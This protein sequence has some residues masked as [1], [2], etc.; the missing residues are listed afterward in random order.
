MKNRL[1]ISYCILCVIMTSCKKDL[2]NQTPLTSISDSQVWSDLSLARAYA[3]NIYNVLPGPEHMWDNNTNRTWVLSSSC[4]EGFN[5][6]DDY[7]EFVINS[8]NVT[9]DNLGLFDIWAPTYNYIQDCNIFLSKIDNVPGDAT[10]RNQLKG[11][12]IYL[13]AYAYFKLIRDYGGVPIVTTPSELNT[14][15]N[16]SRSTFD[17][18]V[19]FISSELDK[20]AALLPAQ[21]TSD[22]YGRATSPAA[23]ALKSTVLLYDASPLWNT[24]ND[25]TKWQKASDAANA[26]ISLNAF[27]L[28]NGNY[29]DLFST[30]QNPELIM[31]RQMNQQY[32][33]NAFQGAEMFLSPSGFNGWESFAPS[34]KLVDAFGM[35]NG[36][37]ITDPGSGY[38]PQHPYV[39]RDPRFYQD[40]IFDGRPYGQPAFCQARYA[41]GHSNVTEFFE[42]GLDSPQGWDNWN[43]GLTRYAFRK[44]QDTTYNF[45]TL[46]QTNKYW[47]ISRLSEIYLNYAEAQFNLGNNAIAIQYLNRL[48]QRAGITNPLPATLSGA[49]L[50][51]KIQNERQ[52]ELCLE[53]HRYYDVRRW[54]IA[55]V[56]EN[57]PLMGVKITRN[58]DGSKSYDYTLQVQARAFKSPQ[59]YLLPIPRT[60]INRTNLVQNPGY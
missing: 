5:K 9:P 40:I 41:A 24:T 32:L 3:N 23:L 49:A 51:N 8:G 52:I 13:R 42:G 38:D 46:T 21:Q 57:Q 26:V 27:Q 45:N 33:W 1:L 14:K 11:E 17:E 25:M 56:T 36:S 10:A 50:Q 22:N 54:M 59:Q 53:G 7:N 60:E 20:A 47:V 34:Q 19:S 55:N 58:T 44:Y 35:A 37:A 6:F 29:A 18:C 16:Q 30:P 2:L 43:A 48:R 39:N 12:V 15:F 28:F 4:D 31:V